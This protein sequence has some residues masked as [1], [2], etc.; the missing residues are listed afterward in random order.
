MFKKASV[1]Q[2]QKGGAW[3][4]PQKPNRNSPRN[5]KEQEEDDTTNASSR[6]G[7]VEL[8]IVGESLRTLADPRRHVPERC[9]PHYAIFC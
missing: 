9:A 7:R 1:A 4:T 3:G 8:E 5:R 6:L 2:A